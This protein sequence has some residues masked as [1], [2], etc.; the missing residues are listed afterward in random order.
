LEPIVMLRRGFF[1][2]VMSA[3]VL[4]F[5]LPVKAADRYFLLEQGNRALDEGD[6]HRAVKRYE[7]YIVRHPTSLDALSASYISRKQYYIRNLLTAYKNLLDTYRRI[8]DGEA[9]AQWIARLDQLASRSD[10]GLKNLYTVGRLFLEH[11]SREKAVTLFESIFE[12]HLRDYSPY[13]NKAVLKACSK[14]AEIYRSQ[15]EVDREGRLMASLQ[16]NFPNQD[17]DPHDLYRLADIYLDCGAE[18]S[19]SVVL[20]Q[21][22]DM[23]DQEFVSAYQ[24]PQ[25]RA[26]LRLR[27]LAHN[28]DDTAAVDKWTD[29][30]V[31]FCANPGLRPHTRYRIAVAMLECGQ[32][33]FGIDLLGELSDHHPYDPCG[34]KA[35]FLLGR[36]SQKR[37]DWDL[38]IRYFEKYIERYP[39][40]PFFALKAY[41]RLI[42]AYWAKGDALG[43]TETE[44]RILAD[45]VNEIADFETQLNMARDFKWKGAGQLAAATFNLGLSAARAFIHQE[46]DSYEALRAYWMIAKY[47]HAFT[48][49]EVEPPENIDGLVAEHTRLAVQELEEEQASKRDLVEDSA[50]RILELVPKV[51][52]AATES[53][54]R[55]RI[56]Y[57]SSQALLL[58]AD[59]KKQQ[60]EHSEAEN[61]WKRFL[62]SHPHHKE[63]NFA[64]YELGKLYEE[65]GRQEEAGTIYHGIDRGM[66]QKMASERLERMRMM[67]G[68]AD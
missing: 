43:W 27:Q 62:N 40:P 8:G 41:S 47:A 17:F 67:E 55:K 22:V 60:G 29:A 30:L 46:G 64:R 42:D 28:R 35:L 36:V 1:V 66:W 33:A 18:T 10:V 61:L 50:N 19:G 32:E 39:N 11:D 20:E 21:I 65:T 24:Q 63:R 54:Q 52:A 37:R 51:R 57:I 12:R 45:I 59:V 15:G 5:S 16:A 23:L 68:A 58:L 34:R 2:A 14:L 44:T 56:Q 3:M 48:G 6:L 53:D 49:K 26:Y 9:L 31:A 4:L 25:M 13:N 38:A 7:E